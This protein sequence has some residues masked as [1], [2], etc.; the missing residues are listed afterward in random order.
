MLT[1]TF[2]NWF[3][4]YSNLKEHA[5]TISKGRKVLNKPVWK[6]YHLSI[7]GVRKEYLDF[8]I[9]QFQLS[10]FSSDVSDD[11]GGSRLG[12]P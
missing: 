4:V 3:E 10:S 7:E 2:Y 6:G 8:N 9:K 12:S 5:F 11:P 1:E